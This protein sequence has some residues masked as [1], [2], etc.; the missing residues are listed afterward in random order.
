MI[1]FK[2]QFDK[3][4]E[5]YIN[6]QVDPYTSCGCFVGNLLNGNTKWDEARSFEKLISNNPLDECF[7]PIALCE[8]EKGIDLI[9]KVIQ[10]EAEGFYSRI[11]IL[12]LERS[13][14][15][16]YQQHGGVSPSEAISRR[17]RYEIN[18][19]SLFKAFEVTLDLLKQIHESKGEVVEPF[20]F[21][22]RQSINA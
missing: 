1:T 20:E 15:L 12:Q 8:G 6:G 17:I 7:L 13:F 9:D 5:A 10:K 11:E 3:L 19:E 4:T 2:Q 22:K 16:T 21:V 18:E 14:M